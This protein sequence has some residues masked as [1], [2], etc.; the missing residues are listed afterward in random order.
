MLL[1]CTAC[2]NRPQTRANPKTKQIL[3][4]PANLF[5]RA[6]DHTWSSRAISG[7]PHDTITKSSQP[8]RTLR[9]L[10]T[11]AGYKLEN[12]YL[13]NAWAQLKTSCSEQH[14][15]L[16]QART[17]NLFCACGRINVAAL[18]Q[19][20]RCGWSSGS[21]PSLH[22]SWSPTLREPTRFCQSIEFDS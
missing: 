16:H 2:G 6:L 7:W 11:M 19:Q 8:N 18:P 5:G 12:P 9:H 4:S 15:P 22:P 10:D 3:C 20:I 1:N 21:L 17:E 13:R 14:P